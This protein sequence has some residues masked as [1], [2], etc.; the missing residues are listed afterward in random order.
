MSTE[1]RDVRHLGYI[2]NIT[3][4]RGNM[5]FISSVKILCL[6]Y[7]RQKKIYM[8]SMYLCLI[9]HGF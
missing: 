8:E 3:R 9:V 1:K 7:K 5:K 4:L 2:E 6:F